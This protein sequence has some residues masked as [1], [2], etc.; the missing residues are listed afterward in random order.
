MM[1]SNITNAKRKLLTK[2]DLALKKSRRKS[3][4]A[5]EVLSLL[6]TASK[7]GDDRAQYALATWYLYGKHVEI[8]FAKAI[9]LLKMAVKKQNKDAMFDLAVCYE[10]GKGAKKDLARAFELYVSAALWG[11]AQAHYEVGRMLFYAIGIP[12]NRKLANIWLKRAE[13]LGAKKQA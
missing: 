8:N 11:D 10:K 7:E 9:R 3:Y 12:K 4:D 1:T 6:S 2:Y 5:E 13:M